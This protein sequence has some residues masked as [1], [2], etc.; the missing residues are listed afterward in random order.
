MW[1]LTYGL[2]SGHP[3]G[4]L[5]VQFTGTRSC[6][7]QKCVYTL[8]KWEKTVLQ[9]Y[10]DGC[11]HRQFPGDGSSLSHVFPRRMPLVTTHT[12]PTRCDL[13]LYMC[14]CSCVFCSN[15]AKSCLVGFYKSWTFFSSSI[16]CISKCFN[17]YIC[18]SPLV[19]T[20][21]CLFHFPLVANF[22]PGAVNNKHSFCGVRSRTWRWHLIWGRGAGSAY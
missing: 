22:A 12:F 3:G 20:A 16:L 15:T 18:D 21:R 4:G 5:P 2:G 17:Y 14:P 6:T 7:H 1:A 19:S 10:N 8:H 9:L 13:A 11:G